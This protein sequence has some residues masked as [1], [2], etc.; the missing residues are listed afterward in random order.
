MNNFFTAEKED[1]DVSALATEPNRDM[2]NTSNKSALPFLAIS[3]K[4]YSC[5]TFFQRQAKLIDK[6]LNVFSTA[7]CIEGDGVMIPEA[8]TTANPKQQEFT[9]ITQRLLIVVIV[10]HSSV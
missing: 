3:R 1:T 6:C 2:P 4:K 9:L 5:F 10:H 7:A 8:S